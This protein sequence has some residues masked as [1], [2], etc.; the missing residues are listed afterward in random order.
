VNLT[1]SCD[2]EPVLAAGW[3]FPEQPESRAMLA[4]NIKTASKE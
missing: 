1:G 2:V 3:L 4:S